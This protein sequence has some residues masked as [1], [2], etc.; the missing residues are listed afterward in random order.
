MFDQR[1]LASK[2]GLAALVSVV[3]MVTFN[4]YAFTQAHAEPSPT[5]TTTIATVD[6]A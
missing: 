5:F 4:L 1:F 6:L 2:V 3:A